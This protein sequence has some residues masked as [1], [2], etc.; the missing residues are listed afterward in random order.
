MQTSGRI[1]TSNPFFQPF[2]S[3]WRSRNSCHRQAQGWTIS[4]QSCASGFTQTNGTDPVFAAVDGAVSPV[5]DVSN[6]NARR[7]AYAMLL[8]RGVLRIGLPLP[9]NA[10]FTLTGVDDPYGWAS[11]HE[12]SLFRLPPPATNLMWDTAVMWMAAKPSSHSNYDGCGHPPRQPAGQP[13]LAGA[14]RHPRP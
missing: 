11:A 10:E 7:I 9:A 4:P 8:N 1:D 6:V 13:G 3:N 12:L 2:G 5:A 14:P